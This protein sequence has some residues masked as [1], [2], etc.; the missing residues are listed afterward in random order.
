MCGHRYGDI[1][2]V[3]DCGKVF[4][5]FFALIAVSFCMKAFG[6]V[7]KFPILVKARLNELKITTQFGEQISENTLRSLLSNDFLSVSDKLKRNESELSKSEFVILLLHLMGKVDD[8]DVL[9]ATQAFD[10]LDKEKSGVLSIDDI[11][12][13]AIKAGERDTA[14]KLELEKVREAEAQ[15]IAGQASNFVS[16]ISGLVMGSRTIASSPVVDVENPRSYSPSKNSIC[17]IST[18]TPRFACLNS[19]NFCR[20]SYRTCFVHKTEYICFNR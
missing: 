9:L 19:P 3:T 8:K 17:S 5:I 20:Y 11:E 10:F 18:C 7:T 4:T 13:E 16:G 6:E 1:F 15:T 2:P 14:R 12:R